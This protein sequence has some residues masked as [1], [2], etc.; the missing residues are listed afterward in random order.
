M[1]QSMGLVE[2]FFIGQ[3]FW[4][5]IILPFLEENNDDEISKMD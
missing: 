5:S 3:Y 1:T 2:G 4:K